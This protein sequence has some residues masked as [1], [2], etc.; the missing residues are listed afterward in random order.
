[1]LNKSHSIPLYIA[2]QVS[3]LLKHQSVR[4]MPPVMNSIHSGKAHSKFWG[5]L[6]GR[7]RIHGDLF[8][9]LYTQRYI[10]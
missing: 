1:M 6:G 2:R 8:N 4:P 7:V 10:E 9:G 5:G 3:M